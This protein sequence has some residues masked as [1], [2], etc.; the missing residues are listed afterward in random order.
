MENNNDFLSKCAKIVAKS[1]DSNKLLTQFS[2]E[3]KNTILE[4]AKEY[5]I[6]IENDN[7]VSMEEYAEII[8]KHPEKKELFRHQ[9]SKEEFENIEQIINENNKSL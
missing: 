7:K 6:A 2:E 5:D 1:P 9:F 8:S 4:L 3:E